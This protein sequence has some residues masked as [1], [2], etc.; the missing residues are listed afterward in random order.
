MAQLL[1]SNANKA[2]VLGI[3]EQCSEFSFSGAGNNLAHD[4]AKD[5]YGTIVGGGA[6]VFVGVVCGCLLRNE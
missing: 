6:E 4:L 1:Q 2:D 3:E 5:M